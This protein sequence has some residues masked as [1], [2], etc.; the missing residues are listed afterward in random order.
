MAETAGVAF[1]A[2]TITS[3]DDARRASAV[4][5][6]VS[7][8]ASSSTAA[9]DIADMSGLRANTVALSRDLYS[10]HL[11]EWIDH[12]DPAVMATMARH[13]VM[14]VSGYFQSMEARSII[15][16]RRDG[17]GH[18]ARF[19]SFRFILKIPQA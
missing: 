17:Q 1:A 14:N 9:N 12:K 3:I 13:G 10:K 15:E 16:V 5:L 7:V 11:T 2:V 18:G 19:Q 4:K 6:D 8:K